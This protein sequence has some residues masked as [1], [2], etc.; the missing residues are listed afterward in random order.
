VEAVFSKINYS[1]HTVGLYTLSVIE[2]DHSS[3]VSS[4]LREKEQPNDDCNL[5][6]G[7]NCIFYCYIFSR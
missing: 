5:M 4:H 7:D 6:S 2:I 3:D 1:L